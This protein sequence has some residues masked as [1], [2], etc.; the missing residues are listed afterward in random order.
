M[1]GG[2]GRLRDRPYFQ[3]TNVR[4]SGAGKSLCA[5]ALVTCQKG[6]LLAERACPQLIAICRA[7]RDRE[8]TRR[9][10][11]ALPPI[12]EAPCKTTQAKAY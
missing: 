4:L 6:D 9:R 11:L 3:A 7:T 8:S 10:L 12:R 1:A 2:V 5:E